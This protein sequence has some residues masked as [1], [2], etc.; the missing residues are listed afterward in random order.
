LVPA[1]QA[2]KRATVACVASRSPDR[3]KHFARQWGI[4]RTYSSYEALVESPDVDVVYNPLPNHLHAQ[5]TV[6][7]V[8]AGKHV[9]CEKPIALSIVDVD[10]ITAASRS[11][12]VIVAEAFMYRHH[13]RTR[14]IRR[15]IA[16]GEIGALT[17]MYGAFSFTSDLRGNYRLDPG[18]GG[19]SLWDVGC[20]P[21]SFARYI[22]NMEPDVAYGRSRRG[23]TGVDLG[24]AGMLAF[25]SGVV[26]QFDAAF[27]APRRIS[28]SFVGTEGWIDVPEAFKPARQSEI[29]IHRDDGSTRSIEV[30]SPDLYRG[31][32]EDLM[33]AITEKRQPE[34]SLEES[35]GNVAAI[36]ALHR[37]VDY[38]GPVDVAEMSRPSFGSEQQW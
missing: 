4:D 37:S 36:L 22:M 25:A 29:R 16:G 20:Y 26:L 21:I 35:R 8:E 12:G 10:M 30:E 31:E 27:D 7:A 17:S 33:D 3:A 34:I 18:M 23:P 28:M 24:F 15:L 32:V 2:S 14:E 38:E 1:I 11:A 6:R 9:L 5:W 19:G 13:A